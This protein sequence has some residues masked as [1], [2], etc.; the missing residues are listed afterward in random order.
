ML[1]HI[2]C[3]PMDCS[4]PGSS[5][6]GI[7]QARILEWVA[8]SFSGDLPNPGIK[9]ASP[10]L[11]ADS[12]PLVKFQFTRNLSLPQHNVASAGFKLSPLSTTLGTLGSAHGLTTCSTL[13]FKLA[14]WESRV[15]VRTDRG[16]T[17]LQPLLKLGTKQSV[18]RCSYCF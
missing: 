1:S 9:S 12:L 18:S 3:D 2:L 14:T 17:A 11:Q 7:F 10:A 6:H 5:V 16:N 8:I 15:S 4:L 13:M